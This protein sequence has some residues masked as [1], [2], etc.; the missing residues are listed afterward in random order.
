MGARRLRLRV[1]SEH[2]GR[3]QIAVAW[4]YGNAPTHLT[5]TVL[6]AGTDA[7]TAPATSSQSVFP[8]NGTV[9]VTVPAMADGS[10]VSIAIG[11]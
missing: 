1:A 10:A 2:E 5:T 7:L 6:A 8:S 4:P 11:G 9:V 3:V